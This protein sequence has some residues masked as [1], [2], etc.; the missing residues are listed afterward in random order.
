M[1][2]TLALSSGTFQ[3]VSS[4]G[5]TTNQT[6]AVTT[7]TTASGTTEVVTTTN[8]GGTSGSL[9][10][11][12][13]T[14][15]AASIND[16]TNITINSD[17]NQATTNSTYTLGNASDTLVIASSKPLTSS[18]GSQFVATNSSFNLGDGDNSLTF[19]S[20]VRGITVTSGTGNDLVKVLGDV[21]DSK[22]TL[23]A[24]GDTLIFGGDVKS[25]TVV[26]LGADAVKDTIQIAD[27]SKIT[28]L[29]ILNATS[30]DTLIIGSANYTYNETTKQWTNIADPK[31]KRTL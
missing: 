20:A 24:G 2:D 26:D 30:Q 23:G 13:Y 22:F 12:N 15:S 28:G 16:P 17:T 4:T 29:S 31:D 8:P 3:V 14:V 10:G 27:G 7:Q 6:L 19:S 25:G 9:S 21:Q 18:S 5:S 1:A 11:V